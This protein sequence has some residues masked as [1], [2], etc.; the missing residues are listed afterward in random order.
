MKM[1]IKIGDANYTD[2]VQEGL[3]NDFMRQAVASA[4]GRFRSGRQKQAE[5]LGNWEDWRTLGSE[6]RTHTL[7]NIDYYLHQ[8][9]ENVS[10]RGGKVFFAQTAEEANEY[11]QKIIKE[12]EAK[13]IVKSKYMVTEEIGMNKAIE[14]IGAEVVES[15]LGEW[16]LQLDEDPPSHIVTPALHKNKEQIIETLRKSVVIQ[17]LIYQKTLDYLQENNYVRIF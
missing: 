11:I 17:V 9:S 12:K 6:I 5:T 2:R 13:K 3:E 7:E 1:G 16:I 8:L 15:D 10:K 14:D 4:Q